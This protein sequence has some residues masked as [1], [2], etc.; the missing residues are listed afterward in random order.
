MGW[1]A[2]INPREIAKIIKSFSKLRHIFIRLIDGK[3]SPKKSTDIEKLF[4]ER[5]KLIRVE[6]ECMLRKVVIRRHEYR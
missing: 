3:F 1:N 4:Y 6:Y 5:E 2:K